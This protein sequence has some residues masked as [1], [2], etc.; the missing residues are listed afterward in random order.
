MTFNRSL[1]KAD[2][3]TELGEEQTCHTPENEF[4]IINVIATLANLDVGCMNER[5]S[6]DSCRQ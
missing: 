4:V 6:E 1:G 2:T 5:Y 3:H